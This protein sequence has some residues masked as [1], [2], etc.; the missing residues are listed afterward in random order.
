MYRRYRYVYV[1]L[2][3]AVRKKIHSVPTASISAAHI[4]VFLPQRL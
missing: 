1:L 3:Y 4:S 2:I